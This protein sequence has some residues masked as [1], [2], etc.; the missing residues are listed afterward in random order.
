MKKFADFEKRIIKTIFEYHQKGSLNCI[1]NWLYDGVIEP[2][3]TEKTTVSI[4]GITHPSRNETQFYFHGLIDTGLIQSDFKYLAEY[5][6]THI[7]TLI[8]LLNYLI[9]NQY[10]IFESVDEFLSQESLGSCWENLVSKDVQELLYKWDQGIFYP[11]GDSLEELINNDFKTNDELQ[12][13]HQQN[14]AKVSNGISIVSMILALI[15]SLSG[16]FVSWL[17]HKD[18]QKNNN[19]KDT[20]I[21]LQLEKEIST[22]QEDIKNL[23]NNDNFIINEVIKNTKTNN[24]PED[25]NVTVEIKEKKE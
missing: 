14:K 17:I 21:I 1:Y 10:I 22:L 13:E 25:I 16:P 8:S 11:I 9:G 19:Q 23:T 18:E 6:K 5:F 2:V 24:Y 12:L 20:E 7:Y 3:K 4:S 15:G